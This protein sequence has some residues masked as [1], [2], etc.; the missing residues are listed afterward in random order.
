MKMNQIGKSKG[1]LF[2]ACYDKGVAFWQT[3]ICILVDSN[4]GRGE[5]KLYGRT[6]AG[7]CMPRLEV[8]GVEKSKVG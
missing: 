7:S 2:R 8:T 5:G 1:Y 6:W 4:L 3:V